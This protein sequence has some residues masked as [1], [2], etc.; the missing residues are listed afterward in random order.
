M[1][2]L[3][4]TFWCNLIHSQVDIKAVAALG[5]YLEVKTPLE[6]NLGGPGGAILPGYRWY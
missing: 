2:H 6:L 3:W 1:A 4:G 5:A